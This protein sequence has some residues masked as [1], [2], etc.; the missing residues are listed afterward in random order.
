VDVDHNLADAFEHAPA[1]LLL[2]TPDGA[3]LR[4]NAAACR[5]LGHDEDELLSAGGFQFDGELSVSSFESADGERLAVVVL[6]EAEAAPGEDAD[7]FHDGLTGLPGRLL[8]EEHLSL[9]L[10]RAEREHTAVAVLDVDLEGFAKVNDVFGREVADEVLRR[11]AQR[12]EASARLSDVV[13]RVSGD[14]FLVLVGDLGRRICVPAAEGIALRV[15]DALS[16]P[17][18]VDGE[19]V[20]CP[21]SVGFALY[22]KQARTAGEL[23]DAAGAALRL[24]SRERR[25]AAA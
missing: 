20:A 9:A 11:V 1:P 5:L 18:D 3:V 7:P 8:F 16:S 10:A 25:D 17:F 23:V 6:R 4:A 19:I 13:A 14:E 24:R 22:P 15:E 12:L 21:A 2:T